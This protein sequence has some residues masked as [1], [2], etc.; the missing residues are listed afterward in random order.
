MVRN[1]EP[2]VA[3]FRGNPAR[4]CVVNVVRIALARHACSRA[5]RIIAVSNYVKNH[6]RQEWDVE[7]H[8]IG[9]V[10]HGVDSSQHPSEKK[11][12]ASASTIASPFL[13]TLGSIRPARGLEDIIRALALI[14]MEQ[15][16]QLVIGGNVDPGMDSYLNKLKGMAV[17]LGVSK[18][19]HWPGH[20]Q[21]AEMEWYF[22]HCE[23][24][25]MTS[26]IEACPNIALEAMSY[27]CVNIASGNPPLPE[28][29][30][31]SALYYPPTNVTIL[32]EQIQACISMGYAE[33][34]A[35]SSAAKDIA[36][37]FS[38]GSCA[39]KTVDELQKTLM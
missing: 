14:N 39:Q 22:T 15:P 34:A 10:Y 3:P 29:F 4:E 9:L 35:M 30:A 18:R 38:W 21:N 36:S 25:V 12:N 2:L 20:L 33:R 31:D 8:R 19:I 5:D 13:F 1:M 6:L 37:R 28:F 17:S 24:F 11:A 26:R 16:L 23:A 32:A 7:E 27:G